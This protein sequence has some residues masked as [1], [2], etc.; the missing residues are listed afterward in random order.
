M[1][2]CA[3]D[4]IARTAKEER[5]K[6]QMCF[7]CPDCNPEPT[8]IGELRGTVSSYGTRDQYIRDNR[9]KINELVR[10]VNQLLR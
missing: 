5:L 2:K 9:C 6:G 8:R 7:F 4:F 10:A 3:H 1:K